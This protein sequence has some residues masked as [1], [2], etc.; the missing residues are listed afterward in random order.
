VAAEFAHDELEEQERGFGGLFV[1]GEITTDAGFFFA[2]EGTIG[3]DTI[4]ASRSPSS[5][6]LTARL[7]P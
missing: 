1:G 5:V 4:D 3:E 7:L 6:I 2:A